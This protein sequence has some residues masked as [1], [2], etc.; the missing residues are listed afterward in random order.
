MHSMARSSCSSVWL[1]KESISVHHL[2][3]VKQGDILKFQEVHCQQWVENQENVLNSPNERLYSK[4]KRSRMRSGGAEGGYHWKFLRKVTLWKV[5]GY[6][7]LDRKGLEGAYITEC[8]CLP[9]SYWPESRQN[10]YSQSSSIVMFYSLLHKEFSQLMLM[11][12]Y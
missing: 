2:L 8:Q 3:K 10:C 12:K 9:F 6:E 11:R 4:L 5:K 7:L 1:H